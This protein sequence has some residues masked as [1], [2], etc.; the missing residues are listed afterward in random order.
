MKIGYYSASTPITALSPHRFARAQHFLAAQGVHLV[1]GTLTGQQDHYRS[2]SIQQRADELNTLIHDETVDVIMATIGGANT[3]AILPYLD[4]AYL[5]QHPKTIV[6]YS[7]ATALLLAVQSQ[8]PVCRV[9]YG[10]ALVAS[11]HRLSGRM[12]QLIGKYM[13][14]LSTY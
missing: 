12:K 2:G 11:L 14:I 4:Y 3:N 8:A 1:A 10:P 6:G 13:T 5:N 9:I 7:D